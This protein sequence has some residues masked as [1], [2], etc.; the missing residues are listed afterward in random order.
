MSELTT[1]EKTQLVL[2]RIITY[3]CFKAAKLS[4]SEIWVKLQTTKD[5]RVFL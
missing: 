5:E 4:K 2:Q 3:L 1:K